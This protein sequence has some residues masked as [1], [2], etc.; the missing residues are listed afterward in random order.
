MHVNNNT[1]TITKP[2]RLVSSFAQF[3]SSHRLF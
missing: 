2:L 3:P 1:E